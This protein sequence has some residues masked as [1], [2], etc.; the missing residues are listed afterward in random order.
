MTPGTDSR[1]LRLLNGQRIIDVVLSIAPEALSRPEIGRLTGLSKPTVSALVAD[2]EAA[3]F[4]RSRPGMGDA[5]SIGRPASQ[6]EVNPVA[7]LVAGVDIGASRTVVAVSDLLGTT[8]HEEAV[9][10]PA[11]AREALD[12]ASE[13]VLRLINQVGSRCS[14]VVVGVPGIYRPQSDSVDQA[15]NLP[16]FKDIRVQEYF[17]QRLGSG[18]VQVENDVNLAALGELAEMNRTEAQIVDFAAISVGT[19]IGLGLVVD[20]DLYRGGTGSAGELGSVYLA[21]SVSG[22]P[23]LTLEHVATGPSLQKRLGEAIEQG[24]PSSVEADSSVSEI[25]AA[26]SAGDSASMHVVDEAAA[27]MSLAISHL[28]FIAD[29]AKIV[30]GG[31]V[32]ANPVF[33]EAVNRHLILLSAE[34]PGVVASRLGGRAALLGAVS[35]AVRDARSSLV[36]EILEGVRS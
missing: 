23:P 9:P 20:G 14:S 12:D 17:T 10:T 15:L 13:L 4:L 36:T 33:V 2:L 6:Y 18:R 19:G 11:T 21:A 1:A 25:L 32:G 26:A 30:I 35:L 7:R 22:R 34:S 5:R 24:H 8:I 16:G 31:G 29:P 27:A 3:G 28:R